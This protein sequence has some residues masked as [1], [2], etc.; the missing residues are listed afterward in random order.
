MGVRAAPTMTMGSDTEE[1]VMV[2][3]NEKGIYRLST[4]IL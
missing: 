2:F 3:P 4:M 1:W